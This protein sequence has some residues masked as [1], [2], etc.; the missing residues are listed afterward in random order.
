MIK[1][2]LSLVM[3]LIGVFA[4]NA[5]QPQ[6]QP[7]PLSP[8]VKA[9]V[10][11]NGLHYYI[12]HNAEPKERANFY[13]AQK[14][15]STLETPEQLGLAHFL[16]HMAFN[17]TKTYPGKAMLNYLQTKGIRFGQDINAYTSFDETVYNINNVPTTDVPL[18]DSVLLVLRDWSGSI[19]LEESEINAE[20]GVIKE[21]WR[22]RNNAQVRMYESILPK[23]YAEYQYQQMPIGK[24][25]IVENF[26]PSVLRAYYKKWY[27]PDQQ[28]IVIVGDFDAA[29][30]EK[31]V[32]ELFSTIPMPQNAAERT[33]PT[34]SDNEKPIVATFQDP[35]LQFSMITVSFKSDKL[36]FEAHN[37]DTGYILETLIP[38]M[39]SKMINNR[40]AE[41]A[42]KPECPYAQSGVYFS[43]FMVSKTKDAFNIQIIAKGD[44]MQEAFEGAMS[45]IARACKTGFLTSEMERARDEILAGYQRSLNEKDK[46]D[47]DDRAQELIRHFIDNEPAPGIEFENQFA[48]QFLNNVPVEAYNQIASALLTPENQVII[49]AAPEGVNLIPEDKAVS[50]LENALAAEYE[51]YVDEV[52]TDP[53]IANLPQPGSIKSVK[54]NKELGITTYTLSNGVKVVIK[55]T[56]FAADEVIFTAFAEG[57][58]RS[59]P[60]GMANNVSVVGDVYNYA[61]IG[62]FDV[63]MLKKYLAGKKVGLSYDVGNYTNVFDG[64]STVK[65]LPSLFELIY[66]SFTDVKPDKESF[67]AMISKAKSLMANYEKDPNWIF[68]RQMAK[69]RYGNNPWML[70]QTAADLD[71]INYDET[72]AILQGLLANPADYTFVFTGNI[73]RATIEPLINQYISSLPT[74]KKAG[75]PK[76]LSS[77]SLLPG[78]ITDE[79]NQ[80]TQTPS[81]LVFDQIMGSNVAYNVKNYIMI[82][83]IGDLLDMNYV[84]TLREEEGGTYGAQCGSTINPNTKQWVVL[85]SFQTN[86]EQQKSLRDRAWRELMELLGGDAKQDHFNKVKEAAIKQLDIKERNNKWWSNQLFAYL[87]GYDMLTG[88]RQTLE[89]MTLPELNKFM[90]KLY[91][92][93]NHV[94]VVMN[95]SPEF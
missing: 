89:G 57:G 84:E 31:K 76:Q 83:M 65:D 55:P 95:G 32:K 52:I 27:R 9:G 86:P 63:N 85:Y 42:Q 44:N 70:P 39:L 75:K 62:P 20:R 1:K 14:V 48:N 25:E 74:S 8:D 7:L 19:L 93:Q 87:R 45:V 5:Q 46:T 53:L 51:P 54:E 82:D 12:L 79:F 34:V 21:E 41:Y 15:G 94:E 36:P 68:S 67:D 33:Y 92:G 29:E 72:F 69:A 10:L 40:L 17:G 91:K 30:M 90:K 23:I 24:M 3:L 59:F 58:K 66:A 47:N 81:V 60:V 80:K 56:D 13:I 28:G 50:T 38:T 64:S 49:I 37:S 22:Q 26:D 2:V 78:T 11:E 71:K 35:E 16:E 88:Y 43:D 18:M 77:V 6:P 4:A 73:D 61:K